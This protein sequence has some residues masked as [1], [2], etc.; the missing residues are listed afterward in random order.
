[1][2]DAVES[3]LPL[4]VL[5]AGEASAAAKVAAGKVALGGLDSTDSSC[6][7]KGCGLKG[8]YPLCASCC[9]NTRSLA[10]SA[11]SCSRR[12][13]MI[14]SCA[15]DGAT[16]ALAG[17][18]A[19]LALLELALAL[20]VAATEGL[21][22]VPDPSSTSRC[23]LPT[24]SLSSLFQP[25]SSGKRGE[26]ALLLWLLLL[27]CFTLMLLRDEHSSVGGDEYSSLVADSSVLAVA[28]PLGLGWWRCVGDVTP[29]PSA[30]PSPPPPDADA[31]AP[32]ASPPPET[33]AAV[34]MGR[35][36]ERGR[37]VGSEE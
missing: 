18:L 3:T 30:S 32:P 2:L 17:L 36:R 34:A 20:P 29:P 19:L 37:S 15:G 31:S 1:M 9:F 23:A 11:S 33:S 10:A 14:S 24:L 6:A 13:L 5:G 4:C 8:V 16:R 21:P 25:A 28:T 12:R 27:F 26:L 35:E 22:L 7:V